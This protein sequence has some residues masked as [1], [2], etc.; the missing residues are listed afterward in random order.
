LEYL[1]LAKTKK[2]IGR[3][4]KERPEEPLSVRGAK[5]HRMVWRGREKRTAGIFPLGKKKSTKSTEGGN[6]KRDFPR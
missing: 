6:G 2:N 4:G 3:S 1:L 5:K